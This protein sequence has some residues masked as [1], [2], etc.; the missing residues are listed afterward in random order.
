MSAAS[1][2]PIHSCAAASAAS[3]IR[4]RA[5]ASET[6]RGRRALELGA[7]HQREARIGH[8]VAALEVAVEAAD[9]RQCAG[10]RAIGERVRAL[11][12]VRQIGAQIAWFEVG[13]IARARFAAEM[14]AQEIEESADIALV[15]FDRIGGET[16]L[17]AQMRD[18]LAEQGGSCRHVG[19]PKRQR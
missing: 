7:A 15:G 18:P 3:A 11:P 4:L 13:E 14:A 16:A 6:G 2:A 5:A 1:R 17:V 8:A 12:A 19:N 10:N 9:R